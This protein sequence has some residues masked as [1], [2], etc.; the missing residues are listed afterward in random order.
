MDGIKV[1]RRRCNVGHLAPTP[2]V[3]D[4]K[5]GAKTKEVQKAVKDQGLEE[6]FTKRVKLDL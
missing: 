6:K 5:K 4:I 1:R 2:E 3:L